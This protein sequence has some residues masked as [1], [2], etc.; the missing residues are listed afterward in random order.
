MKNLKIKQFV[1]QRICEIDK[2]LTENTD[3][4]EALRLATKRVAFSNVYV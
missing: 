1:C 4:I 3:K 2:A